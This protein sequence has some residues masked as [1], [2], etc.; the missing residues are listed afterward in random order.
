MR[1]DAGFTGRELAHRAGWHPSKCSRLEHGRTAPSDSDLRLW[2]RLC[3]VPDQAADLIATTRV[4]D[5]AY[6]EWRRME[7]SGLK[8]A[9]E[10]VVPL[11]ERTKNFRAYS[12]WLIPGPLQT[13]AYVH[14]LLRAIRDRRA[15][16]D[17][18]EAA[19][20]VRVDKQRVL[21]DGRRRF[22]VVLEES[23][24]RHR[25]GGAET[26]AGQLAHLSSLSALPNVS[27]GIIPLDADRSALWPVEDFWIFDDSQVNVEL[28]SAFL[29]IARPSEIRA[30][31][32]AFKGLVESAVHGADARTLI[33]R[34]IDSLE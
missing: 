11:W 12:S 34:A 26:M 18:V 16:P 8:R 23:V 6:V 17:D 25:I 29:T 33:A 14:A 31:S 21:H 27:L 22:A 10:S 7:R 15:V 3:G 28:V 24:L 4:I 1:R 9:Q 5:G 20:Q 30:Y 13:R 32:Q 19:V 2:A